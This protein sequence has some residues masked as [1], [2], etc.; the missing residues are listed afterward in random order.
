MDRALKATKEQ[1]KDVQ[2][3]VEELERKAVAASGMTAAAPPLP[4]QAQQQ[5]GDGMAM[6]YG[7]ALSGVGYHPYNNDYYRGVLYSNLY[8][9]LDHSVDE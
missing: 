3:E 5:A 2:R 9:A 4:V 1:L 6:S 8:P 7:Y